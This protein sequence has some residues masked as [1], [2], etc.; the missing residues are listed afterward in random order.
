MFDPVHRAV[1]LVHAGWR[2]TVL[3]I[4]SAAVRAMMRAFDT[5]PGDLIAGIGPSVGPCCYTVGEDVAV[6]VRASFQG[7]ESLLS[8]RQG[9]IHFDLWDANAIQLRSLGVKRIEVAGLC[10]AHRTDEFYSW[11]AEGAR[12]GRLAALIALTDERTELAPG[13]RDG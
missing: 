12:T 13:K 5:R 10:T 11:R 1:G 3:K 8:L 4:T 7:N 9:K 2:G 6:Q